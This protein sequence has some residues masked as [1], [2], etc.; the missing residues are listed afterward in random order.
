VSV[1][2]GSV[3]DGQSD[4]PGRLLFSAQRR[5]VRYLSTL[6]D[7]RVAPGTRSVAALDR[8]AGPLPEGGRSAEEVLAL[9]DEV[10]SPATVASA[11]PRYFGFV[12]GGAYPVAVAAAWLAAAWDQN[13]AM[14]MMSP[15]AA[16]L[17]E[18]ALQWVTDLL[19]LPPGT[20]GGF[21][22]GATMANATCLAA[23]RDAV[24]AQAGWDVG[25]L[26]LAGSPPVRVIAGFRSTARAG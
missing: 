13:V 6:G 2:P 21:V 4:E 14:N 16:R 24:L 12:T 20:G 25:A 3:N 10:G 18:V 19:G 9:L 17:D 11:G 5:A 22:T 15:V 1:L 26:G 7:R 23:A 8:L